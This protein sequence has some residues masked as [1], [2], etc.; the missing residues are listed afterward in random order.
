MEQTGRQRAT[1]RPATEIL[2]RPVVAGD[3]GKHPRRAPRRSLRRLGTNQRAVPLLAAVALISAFGLAAITFVGAR[4]NALSSAQSRALQDALVT[5]Q[6]I[7]DQGAS[8]TSHDGTL[9]VGVDNQGLTLNG[10]TTV[11]DHAR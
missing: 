4:A 3:S 7:A 9:V 11:V 2:E 1:G 6:L 8:V 10:D 5:R